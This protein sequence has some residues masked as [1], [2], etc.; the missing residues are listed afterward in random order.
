MIVNN[1]VRYY[2]FLL[3]VTFL[4]QFELNSTQKMQI[5][6]VAIVKKTDNR[7]KV[8]LAIANK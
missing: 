2:I 1:R 7:K 8:Y 4:V 6:E 3:Y 5:S